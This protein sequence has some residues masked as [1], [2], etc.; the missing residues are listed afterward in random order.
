MLVLEHYHLS[1]R[2]G[3]PSTIH[4]LDRIE[5]ARASQFGRPGVVFARCLRRYR[6][7]LVHA[8]YPYSIKIRSEG[9]ALRPPRC[10]PAGRYLRRASGKRA[11]QPRSGYRPC[12]ALGMTP[13]PQGSGP[14]RRGG[15]PPYRGRPGAE[16]RRGHRRGRPPWCRCKGC[17]AAR[18]VRRWAAA[19][20]RHAPC[21]GRAAALRASRR[22]PRSG[23]IEAGGGRPAGTA[24]GQRPSPHG[25]AAAAARG[26][27]GPLR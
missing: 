22:G 20:G 26:V 4:G 15:P 11:V 16:H 5:H 23:P 2:R 6:H 27:P 21:T 19:E 7:A 1:T 3:P 13:L 12:A 10:G 24:L 14:R 8:C 17:P 25:R 9:A 18:K